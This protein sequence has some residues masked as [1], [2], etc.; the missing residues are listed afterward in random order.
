MQLIYL[1]YFL[2]ILQIRKCGD[3]DCCILHGDEKP[4]CLPDS[5]PRDDNPNHYQ[6]FD[7]VFST[8]TLPSDEFLPSIIGSVR[9]VSDEQQGCKTTLLNKQN[10]RDIIKCIRCSKP[11]CIYCPKKLD[12]REKRHLKRL[13]I[14]FGDCYE[15]G[16]ILVPEGSYFE[17]SE[18][19]I[20]TRVQMCCTTPIETSFFTSPNISA[21]KNICAYCAEPNT[22]GQ[23]RVATG[24]HSCVSAMF[25][26]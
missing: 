21:D 17:T 5:V 3:P 8:K 13:L 20:Y 1:H 19:K 12:A 25:G 22:F 26:M 10:V 24:I 6:P 2:K 16:C 11:R 23:P 7:K 9:V 18:T 14:Y 4:K 15:C